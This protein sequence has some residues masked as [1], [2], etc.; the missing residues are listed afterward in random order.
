MANS[1]NK[2]T[3]WLTSVKILSEEIS[4]NR[5]AIFLGAGCS[6]AA[7]LPTWEELINESLKK[8]EIKTNQTDLTK[9][10]SMLD[11]DLGIKF[12]ESICDRLRTSSKSQLHSTI[13]SLDINLYVT[14]NYDHLLEDNFHQIGYP[15]RI[16]DRGLDIPTLDETVKTIIKLHGDINSPSSLVITSADYRVYESHNRSFNDFLNAILTQKTMLFLGTSFDD[17]RLR[18]ADEYVVNL[19]ND[20]RR[21]PYIILKTPQEVDYDNTSNYEIEL[22]DFTALTQDFEERGF[23]V[24]RI[25]NYGEI[26]TFLND[27]RNLSLSVKAFKPPKNET[28]SLAQ[29]DYAEF[30]SSNLR[31]LIEKKTREL[32]EWVRGNGVL[33]PPAIMIQRTNDLI[34]HLESPTSSLSEES[35]LE[36]YL[37]VADA[38]LMS[39]KR[40]HIAEARISYEKANIAY[41][42]ISDQKKWKEKILRV[43]A[44][45]FFIEGNIQGAIDTLAQSMDNKTISMRLALLIDA[46]RFDEAFD[47]INQHKPHPTWVHEAIL[48]LIFKGEI[49][50]A[51]DLFQKTINEYETIERLENLEDSTFKDI[52]SY[53]KICTLMAES[54]YN[55]AI[56]VSAKSDAERIFTEDFSVE[57]KML[58]QESLKYIDFLNSKKPQLD[59]KQSYFAQRAK[60]IDMS[61]SALVK[62]FKRADDAARS[63]VNIRPLRREFAEYVTLR[64]KQFGDFLDAI[65]DHLKEDHPD[66]IWAFLCIAYLEAIIRGNNE[67]AW[68][69]LQKA[70]ELAVS[71]GEK[72][73]AA[74]IAFE[75]GQVINRSDKALALINA[76]LPSDNIIRSFLEAHYLYITGDEKSALERLKDIEKKKTNPSLIAHSLFLRADHEIKNKKWKHAKSL[77]ERSLKKRWHP[78]TAERLLSVLTFLPEQDA[79]VILKLADEIEDYGIEDEKI[80]HLKAQA[81]RAT[82]QYNK[83]EQYWHWLVNK[84]PDNAEYSY[85][86]AEVLFWMERYDSA[87]D[88]LKEFIQGNEKTD[89]KCLALACQI[90]EIK[91]D[92]KLAFDLLDNAKQSIENNPQLLLR[93]LELGYLTGNEQASGASL[94]RLSDLKQQGKVPDN[95]FSIVPSDQILEIFKRKRLFME[96]LN[97]L[98]K[99]GQLPRSLLC[100]K[101]NVPLYLDWRVR[102][103]QLTLLT[104]PET[105]TDFTIYSTNGMRVGYS[106]KRRQLISITAPNKAKEIVIDHHALITLHRLGLL[107]KIQKRYPAIYYPE[108][109]NFIWAMEQKKFIHH[110]A[111]RK[112]TFDSLKDKLYRGRLKEMAAPMPDEESARMDDT[113]IKRIVRLAHAEKLSI[114]DAY[115]D[116]D[117]YKGHD[118]HIIRLSQIC[119]WLYSKGK[120]SEKQFTDLR[121][122]FKG[123]AAVIQEVALNSLDNEMRI[124]IADVTLETMEEQGLIDL[125]NDAGIQ[126]VIEKWTADEVRGA[127]ANNQFREEVGRWQQELAETVKK[128]KTFVPIKSNL[129]REQRKLIESPQQEAEIT[130]WQYAEENRIPFL[131]DDRCM[132]MLRSATYADKQFGT[133]ALLTDLYHKRVISIE[134]YA[135]FFLE[136]CKWRYRFLIPDSHIL[137][138]FAKEFRNALPGKALLTLAEYGRKCMEDRG[139]FMG[140]EATEPPTLLGIKLHIL[141]TN[142]WITFLAEIWQDESFSSD[143]RIEMTNVVFRQFLPAVPPSISPEIRANLLLIQEKAVFSE[144]FVYATDKEIPEQLHNLLQMAFDIYGYGDDE[145]VSV[146]QAHLEM[147]RNN[148]ASQKIWKYMAVQALKLFNGSKWQEKQ[149]SVLIMPVMESLGFNL[150]SKII[151][152]VARPEGLEDGD[153][154]KKRDE[155][156]RRMPEY[157]PDGPMLIQPS[158]ENQKNRALIPHI[159][160]RSI[161]KNERIDTINDILSTQY[162]TDHTKEVIQKLS[163][164]IINADR[165]ALYN[166][167]QALIKDFRYAYGLFTQVIGAV[168]IITN[169]DDALNELWE[170]LTEPDLKTVLQDIPMVLQEPFDKKAILERIE[171]QFIDDTFS[172]HEDGGDLLFQIFDWYFDN[173]YFIPV[174]PPLNPWKIINHVILTPAANKQ[175]NSSKLIYFAARDWLKNKKDDPF[176]NLMVLDLI[177]NARAAATEEE[178]TIFTDSEFYKMLDECLNILIFSDKETSKR[179]SIETIQTVWSIRQI[180]ARYFVKYL[181]LHDD[182]HIN[183]ERKIIVA[184]WMAGKLVRSLR[185]LSITH[186]KQLDWLNFIKQK[187]DEKENVIGL[188]HLFTDKRKKYSLSRYT[189]LRGRDLLAACV[190]SMLSPDREGL[191]YVSPFKG[192]QNP[193]PALDSNLRDD[194]IGILMLHFLLGEGQMDLDDVKNLQLP[195]LWNLPICVS[196]PAFL[197]EYYGD[198]LDFLG[199]KKTEVINMAEAQTHEDF[200]KKE[201]SKVPDYLRENDGGKV[202]V[203]L[204]SLS[205]YLLTSGKMP[206][207][208]AIFREN[209]Y[210]LKDIS[211]LDEAYQKASI[212]VATDILDRLY[213]SGETEWTG[214]LEKQL[215]HI[216]YAACSKNTIE[217]IV[218][219][220]IGIFLRSGSHKI[221]EPII[222]LKKSNKIVRES[223]S[224]IKTV[225]ENIFPYIPQNNRENIRKVLNEL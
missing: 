208:A 91:T 72:E 4:N 57:G 178:R 5:L 26:I 102:T 181:D 98:Y 194:I 78:H 172:K 109:L 70:A 147:I 133:D 25:D 14:T 6:V 114:I 162:V 77:L 64:G 193:V 36:G 69:A 46:R 43:R 10:A 93:H 222:H 173:L 149:T 88:V 22:A 7:G 132:Q 30:L 195:I 126:T 39:E 29:Q 141:W 96:N 131:T 16:I 40:E 13:T 104:D 18:R 176:A 187:I 221:L 33:P 204:A 183:E 37:T 125:I 34:K 217:W 56:R 76:M 155:F 203:A 170:S 148:K 218:P 111:S 157:I 65:I 44:K 49:Q 130:S 179:E 182:G 23:R 67:N 169:P 86:L 61:A 134:E 153:L 19:Y 95:L 74:R 184:W 186:T 156:R 127:V 161:S 38:L 94:Q 158:S 113:P 206:E 151:E 144:L 24:I 118:G 177:L 212:S 137:L 121:T 190:M 220:L 48:I 174:A 165:I 219:A 140:M 97:N 89:F 216:D 41:Q 84:Y 28:Q 105:W 120:L 211:T 207:V 142:R 1:N 154:F 171:K 110:Q 136:L 117:N 215:Y 15:P 79:S 145:R 143:A 168:S 85:G 175:Y 106:Q 50:L 210:L 123:E 205:T 166:G 199:K 152:N 108:I 198:A 68:T 17:P 189:T 45:L 53:E 58:L 27:I 63:L 8:Y 214:I 90:Y 128:S 35:I 200:L 11:R 138:Y 146:L 167:T 185:E 180:L 12:R 135:S 164:A 202:A 160:I 62:N 42:K 196:T 59:L 71:D 129:K 87:L 9:I 55:R 92:Y 52:F 47:F 75:I 119:K 225:L 60:L 101:N 224:R 223:L 139:L 80:I 66:Q 2:T 54:F 21:T 107:Q 73:E 197:R 122:L 103:Q 31:N 112:Q 81:A 150:S 82:D 201:V 124:I 83:S 163:S 99:N 191:N 3:T 213:A 159:G 20:R 209:E 116:H 100:E 32:C 192:I 115:G 188:K 51:E